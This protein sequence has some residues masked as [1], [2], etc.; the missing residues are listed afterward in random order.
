MRVLPALLLLCLAVRAP[1]A[2]GAAEE[3]G[4]LE[5]VGRELC[6][7]SGTPVRLRGV[8]I[9]DPVLARAGRPLSDY[10]VIARDWKANVV[11]ISLHP[12]VWKSLPRAQ[13]LDAL[14]AN[15][16]A[17]LQ[18]G[19][20]VVIDWHVIGFPDGY[21]QKAGYEDD[22]PDLYDSSFQLAKDFWM[23][24]AKTFGRDGRVLFE[25][26]NEPLFKRDDFY[27]P[28]GQKWPQ[29]KPYLR[30]LVEIIRRRS[31]N[32]ILVTSNGWAY[33]LRGIRNDLLA[34]KNIAYAWHI[35]AGQEENDAAAWARAL[36]RL[37]TVAPVIVTEW[38]FQRKTR[39]HFRGT[40]ESFGNRFVRDFLE[41]KHLHSIA[42]CWHPEWTPAMLQKD[43]KTPTEMGAFVKRYL[44]SNPAP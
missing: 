30:Q 25:L 21:Y 13:A 7:H 26:W 39:E 28:A 9:G 32:V 6:L 17:A 29:L 4:G 42:W 41:A 12:S 35:Y 8:C 11:R 27:P 44:G 38:G 43:W 3:E 14:K 15:V 20:F 33:D 23:E 24:M 18:N 31:D 5:V 16:D 2:A 37:D 34:G 22:P 10:T 1:L 36:D 19:L 40:P